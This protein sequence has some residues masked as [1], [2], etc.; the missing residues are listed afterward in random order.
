[1]ERVVGVGKKRSHGPWSSSWLPKI[2]AYG[3][4]HDARAGCECRKRGAREHERTGQEHTHGIWRSTAGWDQRRIES[5]GSGMEPERLSPVK[6]TRSGC[7]AS[8]TRPRKSVV[9]KSLHGYWRCK[10]PKPK[11]TTSGEEEGEGRGA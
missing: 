9:L 5:S 3:E 8:S 4:G 6:M 2:A 1:M 11:R 10:R 7:S